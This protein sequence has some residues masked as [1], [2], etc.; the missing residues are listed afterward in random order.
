M[1]PRVLFTL[2][3]I[4]AL[5][6]GNGRDFFFYVHLCVAFWNMNMCPIIIIVWPLTRLSQCA[7]CFTLKSLA[8]RQQARGWS[9]SLG[10]NALTEQRQKCTGS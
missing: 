10:V 1:V 7:R 2:I 8:N 4:P 9:F 6:L 5:V 3:Q